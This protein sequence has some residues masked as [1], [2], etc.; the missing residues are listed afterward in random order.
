[1]WFS[2]DVSDYSSYP[3]SLGNLKHDPNGKKVMPQRGDSL[4]RNLFSLL[5]FIIVMDWSLFR[6]FLPRIQKLNTPGI[7][8]WEWITTVAGVLITGI[9]SFLPILSSKNNYIWQSISRIRV[10]MVS[11]RGKRVTVFL[12]NSH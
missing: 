4:A 5:P 10:K 7:T 9:F 3:R 1:M 12:L 6:L 2:H 8:G 11:L